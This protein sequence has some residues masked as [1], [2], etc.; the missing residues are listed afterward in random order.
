MNEILIIFFSLYILFIFYRNKRD[1]HACSRRDVINS[2]R[3]NLGILSTS[4][5]PS[6]LTESALSSGES[7]T[8]DSSQQ[9]QNSQR[10]QR[11]VVYLHA[12]M[13]N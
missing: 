12:A 6:R 2:S 4:R 3:Y 10:S 9:S 13:G 8:G 11:S 7:T 1:D 5:K